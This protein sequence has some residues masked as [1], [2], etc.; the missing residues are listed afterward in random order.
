MKRQQTKAEILRKMLGEDRMVL[1]AGAHDGLSAKLA[2]KHGFDAIWAS[3]LGISALHTVP[4]ASILSMTEFLQWAVM[5]NES[6]SLPVIADCD[7]GYGNI[8]N[9]RQM[10]EKY[11]AAKIA[12]ICIE[13]K[14][15][16]KL[17]SFDDRQQVLV[18]VDEFCA[19]IRTAKYVQKD[20]DF[21]VIARVE[22]LIA[23]LGQ[24]EAQYRAR[25]YVEAGADAILI[26]SK[27]K[28]PHEIIEFAKNWTLPVPLIVVPTKYPD[29]TVKELKNLGIRM[30]IYA[31]QALRASVRAMDEALKRIRQSGTTQVIEQEICSVEEI[32]NLQNVAKMKEMEQIIYGENK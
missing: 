26:H 11:E 31:N 32:F 17:N 9:V 15:F 20:P 24:E 10:V 27:Q 25:A 5:M 8:H 30:T 28:T 19:K 21:T 29:I 2:E 23:G 22:A 18:S 16:P 12:G 13:D 6:C 1:V 14:V 4:D 3:G 7:S